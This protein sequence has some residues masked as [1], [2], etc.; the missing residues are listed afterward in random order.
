M[1]NVHKKMRGMIYHMFTAIVNHS[2]ISHLTF[3]HSFSFSVSFP[4]ILSDTQRKLNA[5]TQLAHKA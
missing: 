5:E 1:W 2:M 3:R 4:S